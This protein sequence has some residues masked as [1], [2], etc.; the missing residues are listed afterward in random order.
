MLYKKVTTYIPPRHYL[1]ICWNAHLLLTVWSVRIEP[2]RYI[3]ELLYSAYYDYNP[4]WL[5]THTRD[6]L[7]ISPLL[8]LS[9]R[10]LIGDHFYLH[11][12]LL[13]WHRRHLTRGHGL[14]LPSNSRHPLWPPKKLAASTKIEPT[15]TRQMYQWAIELDSGFRWIRTVP[16]ICHNSI[17]V[18]LSWFL[19]K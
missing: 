15:V 18:C 13:K 7:R 16:F 11:F 14:I 3:I 19:H 1:Q 12:K 17:L 10:R 2:L 6:L 5:T 4:Y 9:K 8:R